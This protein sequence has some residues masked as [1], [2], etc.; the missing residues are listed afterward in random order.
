VSLITA[1]GNNQ[2]RGYTVVEL[3][4]KGFQLAAMVGWFLILRNQL[5]WAFIWET[6]LSIGLGFVTTWLLA[7]VLAL[8]NRK[9][10]SAGN[11]QS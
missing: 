9:H 3:F 4:L 5:E 7:W 2:S 8:L 6:L 1:F 11:E 10:N